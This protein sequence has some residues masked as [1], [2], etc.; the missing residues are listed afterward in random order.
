YMRM[1]PNMVV[2][3]PMN[4]MELRNM[5]FTA[6][7]YDKGP[8]SIR[9]PRG[10]GVGMDIDFPFENIEIGKGRMLREGKR[11]A[12]ISI[13]HVG[14]LATEAMSFLEKENIFTSHF[15]MRF[16][17]PI[18]EKLLHHAFT[19][20]PVILTIED[21]VLKGG[22]ADAVSVFKNKNNYQNRLVT[23]GIPDEFIE[24]GSQAEL[25]KVCGFDV[26]S[27]QKLIK[28]NYK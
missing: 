11:V 28:V 12:V 10:N 24:H 25:Y 26:D 17:K 15:D 9:Y 2:A 27:I 8:F 18:D 14:N 1:V 22:L 3:A 16:L 7:Y 6:S 5:L 20:Y 19:N 21:G 13:G 4:E 23:L